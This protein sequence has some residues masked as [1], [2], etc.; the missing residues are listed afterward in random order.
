MRIGLLNYADVRNFGDVLFPLVLAQ[1]IGARLPDSRI[2]FVTPTGSS[3]AGMRSTRFDEADLTSFDA[4]IL[5]G[6]EV[7]HR[8]DDMLR[9]I[10]AR[11]GLTSIERPTDIVFGWTNS[12]V[13]YKAWMALG[14]PEPDERTRRDIFDAMQGLHYVGARG[15]NS[16]ERLR[17]I[18]PTAEV[19]QTPD[20][21]WLFHRL[22]RGHRTAVCETADAYIAVQAV[23]FGDV[24]Q[25]VAGLRAVSRRTGLKIVLVPLQR[26]WKDV[27]LLKT[28]CEISEN[29]FFLVDDAMSDLD[30]L[31]IIE[32]ATLYIGQ[33]MHGF[34]SALGRSRLAGLCKWGGADDKVGELL[35]DVGIPHF[36]VPGWD[37]VEALVDAITASPLQPLL[38]KRI[39]YQRELDSML[40]A[41]C[42]NI[43]RCRRLKVSNWGAA[44]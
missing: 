2:D 40:D 24:K 4:L 26:C 34:I 18:R 28:T 30:K 29:E 14:A 35:R 25:A 5:G 10:Y 11:F 20:L 1:E 12:C 43:A 33:S 6:G 23:K 13:P 15:S 7:V 36:R 19:Q 32:G 3:W 31:A 21:G 27:E 44:D 17:R 22:L 38:E 8:H 37:S 41:V 39:A 9:N 16:A 42:A